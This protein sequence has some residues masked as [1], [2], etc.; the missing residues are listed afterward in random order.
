M[1]GLCIQDITQL[2][3]FF[4]AWKHRCLMD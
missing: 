4:R 2:E 3:E 1:L